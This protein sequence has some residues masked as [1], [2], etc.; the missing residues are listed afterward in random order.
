MLNPND[1]QCGNPRHPDGAWH[2]ATGMAASWQWK[3][4]IIQWW[5][6]RQYGCRCA[7]KP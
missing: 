2:P 6:I 3:E 4:R 5:R 1:V 7:V